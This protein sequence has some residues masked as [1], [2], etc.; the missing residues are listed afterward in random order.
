MALELADPRD[1][2]FLL[3]EVFDAERVSETE[4]YA[5]FNKKTG[6]M[7]LKEARNLAVNEILPTN[8]AGDVENG[9]PEGLKLEN[10]QVQVPPSYVGPYKKYC[11]GGWLAMADEE[12]WGGQGMPHQLAMACGELFTSANCAFLMYPGLTHGAGNVIKECGTQA[13]K[14]KYLKKLFTGEWGGTMCLTEA[15]AG[16]DVGA[17][18][19]TATRNDDG[20]YSIS[21]NKIFISGGDSDLVS[22]V[23]HPVLARVEGA[24]AGTKGI[25]LFLVPK[26]RVNEDGSVGESNDVETVGVEEKMGIHGN[27]TCSLAFGSKGNCIGELIGEE[28]KGMKYMFLL[29]NEARQGVALQGLG[30]AAASYANAVNYAKERIQ[31]P[32]LLEAFN[33]DP[34]KVPIIQHPD[35]RRQLLT[36]KAY[37]E[38]CRYLCYYLAGCFDHAEVTDSEEEKD[39]WNGLIE[40]LTPIAK[41]YCTD[42]AVQ[43]SAAGVQVYGGYGF[44]EEYPQ[45]QHYRDSII[46]TIYEGT[47]GIQAM[48]LLG[49]KLGMKKGKPLMDLMGEVMGTI[50][51]AKNAGLTDIADKL[52]EAI[53]KVGDVAMTI[54]KTAMSEKIMNAFGSATLFLE[55]CGDLCMAWALADKA[56]VAQVALEKAK[57][58]DIP[59]YEGQVTTAK[60]FYEVL[61]PAAM[62]RMDAVKNTSSSVMDMPE[63]GFAS[64]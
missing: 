64:K 14:D 2:E 28:N 47:N 31:G 54:G 24:P 32:N 18:E 15:N 30:F 33:A 42:K 3:Y 59:F 11:E 21:G 40:I 26:Y 12:E 46:T 1:Q 19:T 58:K 27:A 16:S 57:K 49:R 23:I 43:L 20:T 22:N 53:N 37:V 4:K 56:A 50:E 25:S 7:L 61:L 35:V 36:M 17:L 62:G 10:G 34:V 52:Q 8:K 29:M 63:G 5:D 51:K 60:Y 48:D 6:K 41:A 45:A 13:Q 55:V 9:H 38:G 39:K 44:I